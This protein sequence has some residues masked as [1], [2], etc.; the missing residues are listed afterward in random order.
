MDTNI[1]RNIKDRGVLGYV[2]VST[3]VTDVSERYASFLYCSCTEDMLKSTV[4]TL[5]SVASIPTPLLAAV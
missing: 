3:V 4:D 5:R 2:A 1:N